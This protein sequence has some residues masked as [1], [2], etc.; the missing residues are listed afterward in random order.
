[1]MDA[2][3][4][5]TG[6][7]SLP[8]AY[9]TLIRQRLFLLLAIAF[10][11]LLTAISL[12]SRPLLAVDETRYT[13][14]AWEMWY[15]NHWI[16]P[17]LNGVVYAH[18]PPLLF[19]LFHLS[20]GLFGV[21]DISPR[22][23]TPLF[24]LFSLLLI[25][26]LSRA[27]WPD[28]THTEQLSPLVLVGFF[29]WSAYSTVA[30][31]DIVLVF[32]V[33][34][35][36]IYSAEG[37]L[38]E[39]RRWYMFTG[40]F[41]G[42]G[43]L[44]KGPVMIL[45]TFPVLLLMPWWRS[46]PERVC[47]TTGAWYKGLL[48]ALIIGITIALCWVIPAAIQGGHEY[49]YKLLWQQTSN[50]IAES[51]AHAHPWYWY[52]IWLLPMLL[53]WLLI[54]GKWRW[55]HWRY[56]DQG[57]RFCLL[58]FGSTL[59]LFSFV[60]GKQ[61]HYILPVFPALALFIARSF[62][63]NAAPVSGFLLAGSLG[64]AIA[65]VLMFAPELCLQF[66]SAS[67]VCNGTQRIG[68]LPLLLVGLSLLVMKTNNRLAF[69]GLASLANLVLCAVLINFSEPLASQ[70]LK[71]LAN[72]VK[73]LQDDG[74]TTAFIGSYHGELNFLGRLRTPLVVMEKEELGNW[75]DKHQEGFWIE[76]V[77]NPVS[78]CAS[79]MLPYRA[80]T[81]VIASLRGCKKHSTGKD[82]SQVKDLTGL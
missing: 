66:A 78:N 47:V 42:L 74:H 6:T 61:I 34:L 72:V 43:L 4:S 17:T 53:P 60:S 52:L 57:S 55:R 30:N 54:M 80:H 39:H 25:Q 1:M 13:S 48:L 73:Q 24:A 36:L 49:A 59:L 9:R 68:A 64:L 38:L 33:L 67:W 40:F 51:F 2:F 12:F 77:D 63:K 10:L 70:N 45:D 65:C 81:A 16:L 50:R 46:D 44:T 76:I 62:A 5:R 20:W 37:L 41:V 35:A 28:D 23:I 71:P 15:Q 56:L 27:L 22:L 21:N 3:S 11:L 31:F 7:K 58:W 18:K 69:A 19:W 8:N 32:F 82:N 79:E 14:V 26:R 29:V 75:L